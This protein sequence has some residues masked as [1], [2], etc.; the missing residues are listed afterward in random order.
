MEGL[1]QKRVKTFESEIQ[2]FANFIDN[3]Q[4]KSLVEFNATFLDG[5]RTLGVGELYARQHERQA[6]LSEL[7]AQAARSKA[8]FVS[9]NNKGLDRI[10]TAKQKLSTV[11]ADFSVLIPA[12]S[13]KAVEVSVKEFI[14]EF[15]LLS[16]DLE[17]KGRD[18][19]KLFNAVD[20]AFQSYQDKGY[21]GL[22]A[23]LGNKLDELTTV[24]K[25][26]NRGAVDNFPVWKVIAIIVALGVA[27]LGAIHCSWFRCSLAAGAAYYIVFAIAAIVAQ[28][29]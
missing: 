23:L 12:K 9:Y 14:S 19:E 8:L 21:E 25:S 10:A 17:I 15:K 20:Q 24:R 4:V 2:S 26:D 27:I 16:V 3:T 18:A 29:C 11:A 6:L 7:K 13:A 1:I 28:F 5:F 22:T